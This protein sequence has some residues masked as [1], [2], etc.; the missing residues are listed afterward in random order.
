MVEFKP[1]AGVWYT[2]DDR[3]GDEIQVPVT[4][5]GEF[6]EPGDPIPAYNVEIAESVHGYTMGQRV[7]GIENV[8]PA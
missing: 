5:T 2:W 1:Y 7:G 8:Y 3:T 6:H 4:V